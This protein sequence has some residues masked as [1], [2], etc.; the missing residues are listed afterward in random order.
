MTRRT[1][2]THI[3]HR[4]LLAA[5]GR[6]NLLDSV[7]NILSL[8]FLESNRRWLDRH[9]HLVLDRA[10]NGD[11]RNKLN[12]VTI[13]VEGGNCNWLLRTGD[14]DNVCRGEWLALGHWHGRRLVLVLA[15]MMMPV[16]T[17]VMVVVHGGDRRL[18]GGQG[19]VDGTGLILNV[20]HLT[21]LYLVVDYIFS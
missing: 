7:E 16:A 1:G 14:V 5:L 15:V 4:S 3:A 20:R 18:L 21:L 2:F 11:L 10:R 17:M 13:L 12:N 6:L 9:Q 8:R 19:L